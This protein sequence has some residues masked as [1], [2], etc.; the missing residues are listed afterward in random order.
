M[1]GPRPREVYEAVGKR[2]KTHP[3]DIIGLEGN[4][5][6]AIEGEEAAITE[7]GWRYDGEMF[8]PFF[9]RAIIKD[10]HKYHPLIVALLTS[11]KASRS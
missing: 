10:K 3:D 5:Y 6:I 11:G 8:L 7:R 9:R 4:G 1:E 2:Y